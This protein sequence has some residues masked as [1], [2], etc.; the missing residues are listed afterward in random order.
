MHSISKSC[1]SLTLTDRSIYSIEATSKSCLQLFIAV[2]YFSKK[3]KNDGAIFM[4]PVRDSFP[5]YKRTVQSRTGTKI[6]R[7]TA[8]SSFLGRSHVNA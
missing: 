4:D 3:S 8:L 2:S 1:T 6:T 7:Q 5:F